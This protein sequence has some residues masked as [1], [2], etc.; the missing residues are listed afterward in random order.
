MEKAE[1]ERFAMRAAEIILGTRDLAYDFAVV[2]EDYYMEACLQRLPLDQFMKKLTP[3][4]RL[5][6]ERR[7]AIGESIKTTAYINRSP[8]F[9][10]IPDVEEM[11]KSWLEY[12]GGYEHALIVA[13]KPTSRALDLL[14]QKGVAEVKEESKENKY[15]LLKS[16]RNKLHV[17][18]IPDGFSVFD[19]ISGK[20]RFIDK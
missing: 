10:V 4:Q 18:E 8:V 20:H 3:E 6:M 13:D 7:I 14:V 11:L 15:K 1:F 12:D 5:E 16:G 17:Y 9:D 19:D 2:S